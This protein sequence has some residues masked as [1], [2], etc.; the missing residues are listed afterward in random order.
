MVRMVLSAHV[1]KKMAT[2]MKEA[3]TALGSMLSEL[4][5][6][7][8]DLSNSQ[9]STTAEKMSFSSCGS[10]KLLEALNLMIYVMQKTGRRYSAGTILSKDERSTASYTQAQTIRQYVNELCQVDSYHTV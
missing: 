10:D 6:D 9:T 7:F 3:L 4:N 8:V 2:R 1:Q 5:Y